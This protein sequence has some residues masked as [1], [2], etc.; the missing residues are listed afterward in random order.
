MGDPSDPPPGNFY[1]P[2]VD[3]ASNS[4]AP[5]F[6][7]DDFSARNV[8]LYSLVG[9]FF[10]TA[11]GTGALLYDS[12]PRLGGFAALAGTVGFIVTVVLLLRY[13][14]KTAHALIASIAALVATWAFLAYVIWTKPKEVIVHD[15]PTAED[16]K[17]AI[18]AEHKRAAN[19]QSQQAAADQTQI[20]K[21]QSELAAATNRRD[22]LQRSLEETTSLLNAARAQ[23][24]PQSPLLGLDYAK[25]WNILVAMNLLTKNSPCS[26]AIASDSTNDGQKSI[27]VFAEAREVLDN[28]GWTFGQASKSFFPPG[29]TIIAGAPRGHE[30]EC[31]LHL[32]DLLDSLNVGPV[33]MTI[34]ESSQDLTACKCVEVVL[35]KLDKP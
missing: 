20:S 3:G 10:V 28:S 24:G 12:H 9:L 8:T 13:H 15:L 32:K 33:T 30:R 16:I 5:P 6:N 18:N 1:I 11:A 7:K 29:I 34:D 25:K 14:P 22:N 4:A 2:L 27:A 21:L 31:A 26:A 23:V 19:A 35:G 17:E